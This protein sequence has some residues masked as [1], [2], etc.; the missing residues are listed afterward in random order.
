MIENIYWQAVEDVPAPENEPVLICSDNVREAYCQD[1]KWYSCGDDVFEPT[2]LNVTVA[3][4]AWLP[5]GP[6]WATLGKQSVGQG[7]R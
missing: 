7:G 5:K 3:A 2:M 1:G 6:V 4:W